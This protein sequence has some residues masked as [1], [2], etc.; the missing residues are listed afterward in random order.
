LT[1]SAIHCSYS[2]S[3]LDTMLPWAKPLHHPTPANIASFY[4]SS[5]PGLVQLRISFSCP[6]LPASV[7]L[8][9]GPHHHLMLSAINCSSLSSL[10]ALLLCST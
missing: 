4:L 1:P 6:S 5:L 2:P 7:P 10:P 3:L 8:R 9:G